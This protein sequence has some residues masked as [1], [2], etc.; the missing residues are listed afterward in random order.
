M[1]PPTIAPAYFPY[2]VATD[3]SSF[4]PISVR[5]LSRIITTIDP[6]MRLPKHNRRLL[7]TCRADSQ[8]LRQFSEFLITHV[9]HFG[10]SILE[11]GDMCNRNK[12]GELH[13]IGDVT[14]TKMAD[15]N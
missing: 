13:A 2:Y 3:S 11:N 1:T 8:R 14:S 4:C 5:E 7:D 6:K 12:N 15:I 10:G 9:S